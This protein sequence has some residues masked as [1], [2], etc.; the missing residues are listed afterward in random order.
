MLLVSTATFWETV[1][2]VVM[3]LSEQ[4]RVQQLTGPRVLAIFLE[5]STVGQLSAKGPGH[6]FDGSIFNA[7]PHELQVT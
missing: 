6:F 2:A 4:E 7:D 1:L 3:K 5:W